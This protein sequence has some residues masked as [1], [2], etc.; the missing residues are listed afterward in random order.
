MTI[1]TL[2]PDIVYAA[3]KFLMTQ[4]EHKNTAITV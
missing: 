4:W 1:N 3:K 2:W